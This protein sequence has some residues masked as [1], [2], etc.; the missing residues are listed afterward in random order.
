MLTVS[1]NLLV[2]NLKQLVDFRE[3][4][5]YH[6]TIILVFWRANVFL[7]GEVMDFSA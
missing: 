2:F 7:L 5:F 1:G 4:N 6:Q 3:Q